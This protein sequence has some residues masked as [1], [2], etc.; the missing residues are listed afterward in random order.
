RTANSDC[1]RGWQALIERIRKVLYDAIRLEQQ[2]RARMTGT[3]R[4]AHN[5]FRCITDRIAQARIVGSPAQAVFDPGLVECLTAFSDMMAR[6][7]YVAQMPSQIQTTVRA[8]A[9][10]VLRSYQAAK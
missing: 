10:A 8:I 2:Y 4:R 7:W 1:L 6:L 3:A 5:Y 9:D